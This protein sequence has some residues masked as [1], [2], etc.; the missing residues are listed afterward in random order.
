MPGLNIYCNFHCSGV[1]LEMLQRGTAAHRLMIVP[2]ASRSP[3]ASGGPDAILDEA[4]IAVG[5]PHPQSI[6]RL[7]RLRWTHLTSAGYDSYDRPEIRQALAT[8]SAILTNSSAVFAEPC[9]QHVLAFMLAEMRR[10]PEALALRQTD[11]SWPGRTLRLGS[12]LLQGQSVLLVGYGHIAQRLVQLLAPFEMNINGIRRHVRGDEIVKT[13]N[14]AQADQVLLLADHVI[15]LLP[16]GLETQNFFDGRRFALMK[17]TAIFYNVG[18]GSTVDQEALQNALDAGQLGAAY[19]DV[20]T[21]EPLGPDHPLWT[22]PRCHITPHTA[23]GHVKLVEGIVQHFLANL[24]RF[25]T[26]QPLLDQI[27]APEPGAAR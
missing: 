19:L 7:P 21:P 10:L 22:A 11:H 15:D 25:E 1:E 27:V 2:K 3:L 13:W 18:R 12:R 8:R 5:Q 6:A 16:G 20:T 14:V 23:G 24:R 9:A 4:D 17:P 26:G